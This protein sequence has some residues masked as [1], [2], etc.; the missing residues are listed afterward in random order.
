MFETALIG[1]PPLCWARLAR[2]RV[3]GA[4]VGAALLAAAALLIGELA[5][6]LPQQPRAEAVV[7]YGPLT[8]L[9]IGAGV[10]AE[11]RLRGRR[12]RTERTYHATVA[13]CSYLAVVL[14]LFTPY[15][16]IFALREPWVPSTDL[17]LPLPPGYSVTADTG[18]A[19]GCGSGTCSR[20]LTVIGPAGQSAADTAARLRGWLTTRHGW[21]LDANGSGSR[22][23]GWLLDPR[24]E[25]VD[26]GLADQRVDILLEGGD[27]WH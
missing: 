26:V 21:R 9:L 10:L 13:L 11:R 23:I 5:G 6:L 20:G 18:T 1:M 19:G 24:L 27:G 4:V 17:V 22:R 2:T 12:P 3:V 25:S 15:Y 16:V 8:A 7:G 14:L